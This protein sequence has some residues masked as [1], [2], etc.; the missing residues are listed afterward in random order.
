MAKERKR[1]A[2]PLSRPASDGGMAEVRGLKA[3]LFQALA[4]PTRI[5]IIECLHAGGSRAEVSVG[6]LLAETGVPRANLSQHLGVLRAQG[7]VTSRKEGNQVFCALRDRRIGKVLGLMRS[8][9]ESALR[10]SLAVLEETGAT[11][12]QA[13]K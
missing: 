11:P 13:R 10:Q 6:E 7:L 2:A 8:I 4:N 9:C 3:S 5:H 12:P 1:P